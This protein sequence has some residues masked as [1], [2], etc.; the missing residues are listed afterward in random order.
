M[1]DAHHHPVFARFYTRFSASR[2]T[3][4]AG[5]HRD[6]LLE[7]LRGRVVEIGPGNGLNF[8][9]LPERVEELLAVEPEPYLRARA[10]EAAAAAP[11][12]VTVVEGEATS[13][14]AEDETFDA[15]ITS[16]VL[17]SVPDQAA[18][19]AEIRRVVRPGGELRFYE[20]VRARTPGLRRVQRVLD[21]TVWPRFAAGCHTAR[22]TEAAIT[23]AGFEVLTS[24]RFRFPDAGP[25]IPTAPH[26]LGRARIP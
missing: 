12:P 22:E 16:L 21:R 2:E 11:V 15:A 20:H 8:R 1:S 5:E 3:R 7:G 26:V 14:P 17:C 13:I 9:H 4:G 18:A 23:A 6:R 19:L 24:E 10:R 25:P